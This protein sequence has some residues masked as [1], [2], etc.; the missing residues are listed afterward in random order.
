MNEINNILKKQGYPTVFSAADMGEKTLFELPLKKAA[1]KVLGNAVEAA[2]IYA[3]VQILG[4]IIPGINPAFR[5]A[6]AKSASIG[7]F[8][9]S[10]AADLGV[11]GS[12]LGI[13]APTLIGIGV[14]IVI[15]VATYKE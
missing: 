4:R 15:F 3:G 13:G 11:K 12:I 1:G 2:A 5:D 8:V 7:Y 6:V 14:A 10:T 9:G